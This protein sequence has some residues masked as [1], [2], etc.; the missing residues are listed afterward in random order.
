MEE[1]RIGGKVKEGYMGGYAWTG[2]N[3]KGYM[4]YSE[5]NK[6]V[7]KAFK[8]K[9]PNIKVSCTGKSYSGG[10]S[11]SGTITT[12]L[13]ET[14]YSYD[15]FVK[16]ADK[17]NYYPIMST[18]YYLEDGTC[19]WGEALDTET[20]MKSTYNSY[21]KRL[22][23]GERMTRVGDLDKS[24]IKPNVIKMVEYLNDLYDSFNDEDINGMVDY[25]DTLFYKNIELCCVNE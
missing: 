4:S 24:I 10:Q 15:E 1:L 19:K 21:V 13:N 9:Y 7:K 14:I 3:Y 2:C 18:W 22:M 11:C 12:K 6:I 5:I 8:N 16:N 17:N 20:R 25:F 23:S